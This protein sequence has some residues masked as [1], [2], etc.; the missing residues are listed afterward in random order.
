MCKP[1]TLRRAVP[2]KESSL[3]CDRR[4]RGIAL[5]VICALLMPPGFAADGGRGNWSPARPPP[6]GLFAY[7][8]A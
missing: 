2:Q 5:S 3:S 7:D 1:R 4:A 8:A 6:A